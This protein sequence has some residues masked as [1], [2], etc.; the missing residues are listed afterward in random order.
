MKYLIPLFLFLSACAPEKKDQPVTPPPQPL[1]SE[2]PKDCTPLYVNGEIAFGA[3]EFSPSQVHPATA[4]ACG[5]RPGKVC[6][7]YLAHVLDS[8]GKPFDDVRCE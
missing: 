8:N 3:H 6:T 1:I 2:I 5:T 7:Y 4:F